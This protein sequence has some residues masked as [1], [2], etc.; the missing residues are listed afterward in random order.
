MY[1]HNQEESSPNKAQFL[2]KRATVFFLSLFCGGERQKGMSE[3]VGGRVDGAKR[4]L[5]VEKGKGGLTGCKRVGAWEKRRR[6]R[7]WAE[8]YMGREGGLAKQR[9]RGGGV[10]NPEGTH[11][12]SAQRFGIRVVVV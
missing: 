6:R 11:T 12:Q 10:C 2:Q 3:C 1:I 4:V 8:G 7:Q 9:G 5:F